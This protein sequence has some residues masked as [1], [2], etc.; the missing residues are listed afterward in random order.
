MVHSNVLCLNSLW[1][2]NW[3]VWQ[4]LL[5]ICVIACC[6]VCTIGH[7]RRAIAGTWLNARSNH[8]WED[9]HFVWSSHCNQ[10]CS[11]CV[12]VLAG[13]CACVC[14]TVCV[15]VCCICNYFWIIVWPQHSITACLFLLTP[16]F[17]ACVENSYWYPH[18]RAGILIWRL[19]ELPYS[20]MTTS[21]IWA[22]SQLCS[23][24]VYQFT[25]LFLSFW[26]NYSG[27]NVL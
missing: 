26:L 10:V 2:I 20:S 7:Q 1:F 16:G 3:W 13:V 6:R 21:I 14:V 23:Q 22:L 15:T 9:V 12:H 8:L 17:K 4:F 25:W 27:N 19:G 24:L 18:S 11:L 5:A